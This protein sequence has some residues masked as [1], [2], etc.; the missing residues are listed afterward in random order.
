MVL[1]ENVHAVNARSERRSAFAVPLAANPFLILAILG[2]QG[3]HVATMYLPGLRDILSVQPI[4]LTDWLL[5]ACL[6]AS[7][8]VVME[9]Y[10]AWMKPGRRGN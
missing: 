2:A 6:A 5:V 3:L 7:L 9:L 8:L 1:F 4:G 10:K